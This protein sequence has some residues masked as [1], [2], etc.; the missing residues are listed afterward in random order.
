ML[1]HQS[2]FLGIKS[3]HDANLKVTHLVV[4][5]VD[6]ITARVVYGLP[7][8]TWIVKPQWIDALL[9]AGAPGPEESPS[10]LETNYDLYGPDPEQFLAEVALE[11]YPGCSLRPDAARSTLF[12]GL[13]IWVWD[14]VQ[15]RGSLSASRRRR[16]KRN[17][18]S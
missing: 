5:K 10:E 3:T 6:K 11:K 15:V 7:S 1:P 18:K 13:T 8:Q 12:R 4:P 16:T 2:L 9:A 17:S 14:D